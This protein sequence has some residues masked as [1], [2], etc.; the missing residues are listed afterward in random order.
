MD[1]TSAQRFQLESRQHAESL[2]KLQSEASVLIQSGR[3][4]EALELY[5]TGHENLRAFRDKWDAEILRGE[6]SFAE[7]WRQY[8]ISLEASLLSNEGLALRWMG[9]LDEAGAL[10][11]RALAMT[12]AASSEHALYLSSLGGLR[13]NQQAYTEAEEL[14][15]RAH[16]EFATHASIA[17]KSEPDSAPYFWTQAAQS[18]A[19][20]AYAALGRGDQADFEKSFNE[21]ISF[22]GQHELLELANK[23]WLKQA[24]YMLAGDAS[25]ETIQRIKTERG[26][27][28]SLTK[29]A[30]FQLEASQLLAE[31]Y[32]ERGVLH[33]A[34]QEL[35]EARQIAPPHRQWTL[36]RQLADI[37]ETQKETQAAL[38]YSQEAL[39]LAR[40]LGTPQAVAASLR[41]LVSLHSA[42]NHVEAERHL[43]ELRSLGE[44]DEIK[45]ALLA[46]ASSYCQQKRFDLASQDI[47]E[48]EQLAPEDPAVLLNRVAL[49]RGID[50]KEEAL[51]V[52]EKA[53]AAFKKQIL[54]SGMDWK[55]GLD[56]L[57]ALHESGAFVAAELE[58]TEEAF[59]WAENGKALRLRSRFIAPE[60]A[61]KATNISF[62]DLRE[63]LRAESAALLFFCVTHRGT[64]AL[65]CD[66]QFDKPLP[67]FID[68][69]EEALSTLLPSDKHDTTLNTEV[70]DALGLLSERLAPCLSEAVSR[71]E[72]RTLYIVP[73][74]QLYFVP[75]AAMNIDDGTKLIDHC[76]VS[77]L[78]CAALLVSRPQSGVRSRTCLAAGADGEHGFS[79]SEQA[80]QIAALG[81][82][83]SEC[84]REVKAQE[85]LDKAPHFG[86]LH[87]Q[88]HGRLEG[89]L[90]GTRSASVLK[91]ADRRLS[92]AD[93][94]GLSLAAQVVFLNA[95]VT[96]RFQS[97]LS[98]EVGGFWE[99]FLYAGASRVIVT[100]A[101]V[102]PESA[103]R[104]ALAFYRH[105]LNG[106]GA[107]EALRQAQLEVR[108]EQPDPYH[109]ASH[110][111]IGG[112]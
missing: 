10:F 1:L 46:R 43:S 44:M 111:L 103:Q 78:P 27:R 62:S 104:I 53:V 4:Q 22:A 96:G 14:L 24:S 81:W 3:A 90:P 82:D 94:Y 105:W 66:P 30:D 64:L 110:I 80:S 76:A 12:P 106:E 29:S 21:A 39:T 42:S 20:S 73:D 19:D 55:S 95:C 109:W 33:L 100:L 89:N 41:A 85:L 23:F 56:S 112:G 63:R 17:E 67:F 86:I 69:N 97:R 83:T 18:L 70:F 47:D 99:A 15:R 77:Y 32:R 48:A 92:A 9:K 65:L 79:F 68:L 40:Q 52:I 5:R 13:Y 108:R 88:C 51:R 2:S 98:S 107:G 35:E 7:W 101:Y 54:Q 59:K 57:A 74:S 49:L 6:P 31:F 28:R 45:N 91:L 11:E 71:K 84:L 16:D 25:G 34:R 72:N 58:R 8:V 60:S 38:D 102:H 93:V 61:P 50:A 37:A 36:L 26:K 75:F 87:L